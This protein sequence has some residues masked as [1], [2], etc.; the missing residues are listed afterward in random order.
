MSKSKKN[1]KKKEKVIYIDDG[2]TISD[3][4]GINDTRLHAFGSRPQSKKNYN[5]S[6]NTK[7]NGAV[8]TGNKFKDSWRTYFK[9]VKQMILPML[10]TI[11]IISAAFLIV[12]ILLNIAS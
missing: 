11:A 12:W 7:Y 4:S 9:A 3:M 6:K 1:K 10:V 2:S 5:D 8:Y